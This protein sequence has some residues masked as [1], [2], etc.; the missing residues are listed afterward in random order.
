MRYGIILPGGAASEQVQQ[1]IAAEHAGWD[2]VFVW[3]AAY[4]VDAWALLGAM[5]VRTR[6]VVL[7]TMLTPLP[8]RR[9]WKV[10]SQ[11]ETVDQLSG[12]RLVLTVGIGAVE[13]VLP[14][15]PAEP[16]E[17]AVR[18][19]M[20]D[21]GI[22]LMRTLWA[23]GTEYAGEH[24]TFSRGGPEFATGG[25]VR[26]RIPIWVPVRWHKPRSLLRGARCEGVVPEGVDVVDIPAM[27][28]WLA[29]HDAAVD[30][31]VT[32]EGETP[33]DDAGAAA[34]LVRP[35]AEAGCTWWLESKWQPPESGEPLV[36]FVNRRIAAGPPRV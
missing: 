11:A 29:E 21:E 9:P 22:D 5:A 15:S 2:G 33:A 30:L 36:D 17:R 18:A 35:W 23:G 24:Y 4:G 20:L 26:E 34:E 16:T 28:T 10:A 25:G 6:T 13:S 31:D 7:G 3:E 12:G 1:A 32:S 27:R 14:H 8:W 19:A